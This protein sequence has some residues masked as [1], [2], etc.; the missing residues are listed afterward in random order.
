M[1]EWLFRE[2]ASFSKSP[3]DTVPKTAI[4]PFYSYRMGF[5]NYMIVLFKGSNKT[6]PIIPCRYIQKRHP[7]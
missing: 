7:V 5:A 1:I 4:I 2:T 3:S 6:L